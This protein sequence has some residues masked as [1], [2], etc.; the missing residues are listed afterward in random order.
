MVEPT[1]R[2]GSPAFVCGECGLVYA[3]RATAERCEAWCAT[4]HSCNLEI[5]RHALTDDQPPA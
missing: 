5:I 4:H 1:T 3:D 2:R